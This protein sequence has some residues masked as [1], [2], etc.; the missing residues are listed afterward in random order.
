MNSKAKT[1]YFPTFE[2]AREFGAQHCKGFPAWRVVE[3]QRGFAVQTR[4]SG[5]YLAL[6]GKPTLDN[7]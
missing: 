1:A 2:Q 3:Y 7:R 5:D 6:D 4:P